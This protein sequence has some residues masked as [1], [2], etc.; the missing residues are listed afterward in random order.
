MQSPAATSALEIWKSPGSG[1]RHAPAR[2]RRTRGRASKTKP[3]RATEASR[4]VSPFAPTVN[5]RRGRAPRAAAITRGAMSLS[6]SM[7]AG[8]PSGRRSPEQPQLGG[9]IVLDRRVIVHVVA[10]Q[11]GEGA[12]G[13]A[14]AVEPLLVEA[15]RRGLHREMRDAARG[16]PVEGLMQRDRVRRRQRSVN[17][18]RARDDAD[19][20]DRGGLAAERR[21]RSGGR[22]RR[23]R[24]C[25]WCR[26]PRR[27]FRAGADR[28]A[29]RRERARRGRRRP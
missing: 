1:R 20:P 11:I 22:R 19:R 10:R 16:E 23:P 15:V 12:G 13:E 21:A 7:T 24:S 9:E 29:R 3:S 14:H 2:A 17:G 18:Q 4:I 25:R 8:A 27:S 6:A 26:S 5:D 28:S